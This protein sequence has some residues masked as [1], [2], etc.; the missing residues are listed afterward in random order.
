M[1]VDL[2]ADGAAAAVA[3]SR[4][5]R[6]GNAASA[7]V[8]VRERPVEGHPTARRG[9]DVDLGADGAAAAAAASRRERGGNAASAAVA[10]REAAA[11]AVRGLRAALQQEEAEL[12]AR[13]QRVRDL[14]RELAEAELAEVE[15]QLDAETEEEDVAA[16]QAGA[17][18]D[19][20]QFQ[21]IAGLVLGSDVPSRSPRPGQAAMVAATV[22]GLDTVAVLPTGGGKTDGYVL[23]GLY[24]R[25]CRWGGAEPSLTVGLAHV[26]LYAQPRRGVCRRARARVLDGAAPWEET[27]DA[28][29]RTSSPAHRLSFYIAAHGAMSCDDR[30]HDATRSHCRA[31]ARNSLRRAPP[32]HRTRLCHYRA[33]SRSPPRRGW[34]RRRLW[35]CGGFGGSVIAVVAAVAPRCAVTTAAAAVYRDAFPREVVVMPLRALTITTVNALNRDHGEGTALHSLR[36]YVSEAGS[37]APSQDDV[38]DDDI[39]MMA[40]FVENFAD[41]SF[42]VRRSRHRDRASP[43]ATPSAL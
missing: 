7:A 33:R 5:E 10:V 40:R 23:P 43:T 32:S 13:Q 35:W 24:H 1:D 8:A 37:V 6:G 38:G 22:A 14:Q 31:L 9:M 4:R 42:E 41:D 11:T 29:M 20:E 18:R 17:A 30:L 21:S 27:S 3:A 26:A 19:A 25:W 36:E 16:E 28:A 2:G 39:P 15:A 34:R 12:A